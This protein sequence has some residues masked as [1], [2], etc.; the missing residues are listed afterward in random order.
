MKLDL[1]YFRRLKI[2]EQIIIVLLCAVF[3][4]LVISAFIINNINQHAVRFQLENSAELVTQVV[5]EEIDVFNITIKN[6]LAQIMATI[7]YIPDY[8]E[9]LAY[10]KYIQSKSSIYDNLKLVSNDAEYREVYDK[11]MNNEN[12]VVSN[13]NSDGSYIMATFKTEQLKNNLF[14]PFYKNQRQI[15]V[16]TGDNKLVASYNYD[17]EVFKK[18]LDLLPKK[19]KKD[20]VTNYGNVKNQPLVYLKKTDPD[21]LIIVITTEMMT[22][23]FIDYNRTKIILSLL[24]AAA[25]IIFVVL[26]Y[27]YYLYINIR[28]LF[29]G[30][31]ALSK[32]NYKRQI[33][34]LTNVFTPY[35]IVFLAFEFNKMAKQIHKAYTQLNK[36]NKELKAVN[37]FRSNMIDTVSHEFRT[38]L[39]S[40]Q[41]YT[42]RLMRQDIV[43]DDETKQKSLRIIKQQSERLSRMVEDILVIPD[44]ET[45]KLNMNMEAVL[46]PDMLSDIEF[47]VKAHP[48]NEIINNINADAP[49]VMADVDRL[50]QVFVNLVDNA[51]KY[52]DENTQIIID[53][54]E[55]GD[56]FEINIKNK[57]G[58]I[59]RE[60]LKTLFD[61]FTRLD[62]KTTRTT[63]GTGL[64]LFIV[65]GLL[66]AMNGEIRL[67]SNEEFGFCAKV[68]LKKAS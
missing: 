20:E 22:K 57:C 42:S 66:E 60:K 3:V 19:L 37:E 48:S 46:V 6:N 16:L 35:E 28:Q 1:R 53:G 40:I 63:R 11:Y 30:I 68:I 43:I 8:Q 2:V 56:N 64:G 33:R 25:T 9:K 50:E 31:M 55:N 34:L 18:S 45:Q 27:T 4:P 58:I 13:Q 10:L 59:P 61:K 36:K 49:R 7:D 41:G 26:L 29:K 17:E 21:V 24:V 47:L 15:Y 5:S 62:D 67:Y 14:R 23:Q 39:T 54:E 44:I 52:A 32:G 51:I 12:V 38:P 65:K